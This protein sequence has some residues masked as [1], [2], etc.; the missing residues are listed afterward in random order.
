MNN[1]LSGIINIAEFHNNNLKDYSTKYLI[2][3]N[4]AGDQLEYFIKDAIAGSFKEDQNVKEKIFYP[5]VFSYTGNQNNPPDLMIR[6]GDAFEVKKISGFGT[7]ALNSSPPKDKLYS[8]DSRLTSVCRR[9][10]DWL[11][12]DFFY[13]IGTVIKNKLK[14]LFLVHGSCYA[15]NKETYDRI[16]DPLKKEIDTLIDSKGL[17]KG[18]TNELGRINKVDPLGITE[19][20]IRGMW[21]IQHPLKVFSDI[22]DYNK[23]SEFSLVSIMTQEK[24][25]SF[26]ETIRKK[27]ESHKMIRLSDIKIKDPNNP[28]RLL[29]AKL[30][31][32]EW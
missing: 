16:N 23:N 12:K 29:N 9:C 2:R 4:A 18:I 3:I 11:E 32:L 27:I 7:I 10:E 6:G 31:T 5:K 19:L 20:R 17:E 22:Y 14:L 1:I 28:A 30:I 15:A 25:D 8:S 13:T 26:S 21:Q 24:Y